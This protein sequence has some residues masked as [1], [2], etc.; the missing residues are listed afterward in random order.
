MVTKN[1]LNTLCSDFLIWAGVGRGGGQL[2]DSY[3]IVLFIV[4][5]FINSQERSK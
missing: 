3:H 1:V 4:K 2:A 5:A